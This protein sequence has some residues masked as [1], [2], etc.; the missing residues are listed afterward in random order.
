MNPP[1]YM[2]RLEWLEVALFVLLSAVILVLLTQCRRRRKVGIEAVI[3]AQPEPPPAEPQGGWRAIPEVQ[4][5]ILALPLELLWEVAQFPL[6]TVWHEGDWGYI[7]YGLAHCT[8]GDVLILLAIYELVAL[9]NINRHWIKESRSVFIN[10]LIFTL[11]GVA[12]TIFSEITNVR[13]KG[14]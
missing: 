12:Y 3:A 7:L 1:W 8:L 5:L 11:A 2:G 4:L 13:I 9:L 14:T 6:F 10:G